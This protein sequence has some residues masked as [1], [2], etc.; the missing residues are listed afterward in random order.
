MRRRVATSAWRAADVTRRG[1]DV[2][3]ATRVARALQR[4]GASRAASTSSGSGPSAFDWDDDDEVGSLR[5]KVRRALAASRARPDD[6]AAS[7]ASASSSAAPK[8]L[9]WFGADRRPAP[10]DVSLKIKNSVA[11]G[12]G[13]APPA[14]DPKAF[15][16][17]FL[18]RR[19]FRA[20]MRTTEILLRLSDVGARVALRRGAVEDRAARLRAHF[21]VLGPAFVKLGQVLST[22][23]D[24][25]PPSYC[26]ELTKL[27]ENLE[28]ITHEHAEATLS[29]ELDIVT[30]NEVFAGGL[31]RTPV[32]AASLA[33]VYKAKLAARP[34]GPA[35]AVKV[36]RPGLAE[37]VALDATI[38]RGIALVLR[39]V[40]GLRSDVV[41]IVDELVGRIFGELDYRAERLAVERFRATYALGGG[42]GSD[43]AGKVRAPR[44][45]P[46]LST[47][48]VLVM[49]WI[50][51][52][53]LSDA[54]GVRSSAKNV[55]LERGVRCSLH[56]LLETGFM[57]ADPH[58]G[59]LVVDANTGALTYLDF[60]MTV[61][62]DA[63]RR[64]AMLRGLVGF[65]NRDARSLVRD[66]V[67][68]EFLPRD[69]DRTRAAYALTEVFDGVARET[70]TK[71]V[72]GTN[73]FLGVVSQLGSALY[74]FE[75]R[76]P[77]YFARILRALAALEGVATGVDPEF[78]VIERVY[79]YVLARLVR[80]PDPETRETLRRLVLTPDGES[81]RWRRVA[82]VFS[83][84]A[85]SLKNGN[86]NHSAETRFGT[87]GDETKEKNTRAV[88]DV[89]ETFR[90]VAETARAVAEGADELVRARARASAREDETERETERESERVSE[91]ES[92]RESESERA[93][94]MASAARDAMEYVMS[95][96][97]TGLR[98][99]LVRD[100]L[101]ACDAL[102]LEDETVPI[103]NTETASGSETAAASDAADAA[104]AADAT[105][106]L[107]FAEAAREA[108]VAAPRAWAP[109][110]AAAAKK[111][112][113][114]EMSLAFGR[115]VAQR[116]TRENA[117]RAAK[118]ALK[119]LE[120]AL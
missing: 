24:F 99:A 13:G 70:N 75:F 23:A 72:R 28:P 27:Q 93:A 84:V 4:V 42:S 15:T 8:S 116:V 88:R 31:P 34:D 12:G 61:T 77:P 41:G 96:A 55:L 50:N 58:P 54:E 37:S 60:G 40:F 112:G 49:E 25:L 66:L 6:R 14:Y 7:G 46:E 82:R 119:A 80:D 73:D 36:Q 76:L 17:Y 113:T 57:H 83:A 21:A 67:E 30:T 97:G 3:A 89:C 20:L 105:S 71:A 1:S 69:V 107:A 95:P 48:R 62:V 103:P 38:L 51:G 68:L 108:Y 86:G 109:V 65:V 43:L 102:C 39:E 52:V 104:D 59:N 19:P 45:I 111:R 100:A 64:S 90:K 18:Y 79:P 98:A 35:V 78:R 106:A 118:A 5:S 92:E 117:R 85:E 2:A 120:K 110:L 44:V 74:A 22:R 63:R 87:E 29:D 56:Q 53:R 94:A 47:D 115:G 26:R 16:E 11:G 32:A 81:V 91:R 33:A 9:G 101:D 114:A 10:W